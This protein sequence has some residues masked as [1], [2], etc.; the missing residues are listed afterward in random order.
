[1][2]LRGE[3]RERRACERSFAAGEYVSHEVAAVNRPGREPRLTNGDE[4]NRSIDAE[5]EW[6]VHAS[7]DRLGALAFE[8]R[9]HECDILATEAEAV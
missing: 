1:M 5:P 7:A 2:R 8:A 6:V 3:N 9:H 4:T